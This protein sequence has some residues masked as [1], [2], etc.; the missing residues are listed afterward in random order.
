[1][2]KV[3]C[4]LLGW[5]LIL[6]FTVVLPAFAGLADE[7]ILGELR[8][9]GGLCVIV[10]DPV[11]IDSAVALMSEGPWVVQ[12]LAPLGSDIATPRRKLQERGLY[13]RISIDHWAGGRLPYADNL[14]NGIVV[15]GR[16]V[17]SDRDELLRVLVPEGSAW[18]RTASGTERVDKARPVEMGE[19][20]H[21]WQDA[22]GSLVSADR[23]LDAPNGF[24]WIASPT[25]PMAHRKNST[26]VVL[27][28]GGRTFFITQNVIENLDSGSA[29]HLVA[30]D[31]FN[32]VQL[33]SVP[34]QGA[35][36]PGHS[37]AVHE[38]IVATPDRIYGSGRES[39]VVYDTAD[40]EVV[41]TWSMA[42]TP[43]KLL[44]SDGILIAQTGSELIAFDAANGDV[45]WQFTADGPHGTLIRDGRVFCLVGV[46]EEDGRWLHELLAVDLKRGE[47]LWRVPVEGEFEQ[48]SSPALR[49]H[50]A[51]TGMVC[52]IER[53]KLRF[54]AADDGRELWAHESA[55]ESRSGMDSRQ[56]GHFFAHDQVWIRNNRARG[57]RE[58][59]ESWLALDPMTGSVVRELDVTGPQGVIS[60]VNKISCQPLTATERFVLD[61]RL[62]TIWD[63]DGG[64]R[65][66]FKFA[67]GGCQVGMVPANGLAYIP[68]NACGCLSEQIRG[69]LAL[70]HN[71]DPGLNEFTPAP[72]EKGPAYG[73]VKV[74]GANSAASWP[75]YRRS[76]E[77]Q[78]S[79][80]TPV[81]TDLKSLW[82]TV[83][84]PSSCR[85]DA[86]WALHRGRTLTPPVV[87]EGLVVV[88]EPQSHLV[89]ALDEKSG[90]ECWRFTVGGRVVASPTIY[91]GMVM[92]GSNDGYVYA[93]RAEDGE[94][95]WRRRAAPSERKIMVHGQL[96]SVWPVSGGV[97][98]F[99]G[100]ALASAGRAADADGGIMVHGIDP[101][102]G[103]FVW[104]R[105][106]EETSY[107]VQEPLVSDGVHV[108]LLSQRLDP[109]TGEHL[110]GS[111]DIPHLRGGKVGLLESSWTF[112]T[113]PLRKGQSTQSWGKVD[114]QVMAAAGGTVYAFQ[115]DAGGDRMWSAPRTN[116]GGVVVAQAADAEEVSW[117][118]DIESPAQVEAMLL[119]PDHVFISG[120]TNRAE[121]DGAG[122]LAVLSR[123]DG[124]QVT[125]LD[126]VS[127]PVHDGIAAANDSVFLT[128]RDGRIV[129]L[130]RGGAKN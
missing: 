130:G 34:W 49:L 12:W 53:T 93:L 39:I 59:P 89:I 86:E 40:G 44:L 117:S 61:P 60:N 68:P 23:A 9:R 79:L 21:P 105:R 27:S 35:L 111:G 128:L 15:D 76:A 37:H 6:Q 30:R 4:Y 81:S 95:V 66:G 126:F 33:W 62:A 88:A 11:D 129:R 91:G 75:M 97:M 92:V 71:T 1:M 109:R 125:R 70:V 47:E 46:R 55:A 54:L 118:F 90:A 51:G 5:C 22:H 108:Y 115:I 107:G 19:W 94:L 101:A 10:A 14:V 41:A 31:A 25:F 18:V 83:V 48:R 73:K 110:E 80:P 106:I 13:G 65:Q 96:E 67:R 36:S 100:I 26:G 32:G 98:I 7:P 28:S 102:S 42:E 64:Q 99:D 77:R 120:P 63:F 85:N 87:A 8:H 52:L 24:Q 113:H 112:F 45:V 43:G 69:F 82:E 20:S 114:G 121:R 17:V 38:A 50:F 124:Q 58:A 56:V 123:G 3:R 104:S 122:Y 16:V 57:G 2:S 119:S 72:L 78:A 29:N 74:P 103:E 127:A 116:G 84:T